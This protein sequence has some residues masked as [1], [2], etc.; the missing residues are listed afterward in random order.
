MDTQ[1]NQALNE[2]LGRLAFVTALA[3]SGSIFLWCVAGVLRSDTSRER[4]MADLL[5]ATARDRL[6]R[7]VIDAS[8]FVQIVCNENFEVVDTSE[9]FGSLTGYDPSEMYGRTL[10]KLI[11][12]NLLVFDLKT[13]AS[14][15]GGWHSSQPPGR[16]MRVFPETGGAILRKDGT[17]MP[18]ALIAS[19]VELFCPSSEAYKTR[20]LLFIVA[21]EDGAHW[22]DP[23]VMESFGSSPS[24]SVS[25]G[26]LKLASEDT[27]VDANTAQK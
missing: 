25:S 12:E 11:P 24:G 16:L 5:E 7:E 4:A 22:G 10:Y 17:Q 15:L 6:V 27:A 26:E 9:G 8:D 1:P 18:V 13:G 14:T 21:A 19:R 2:K 20:H 3:I 23:R